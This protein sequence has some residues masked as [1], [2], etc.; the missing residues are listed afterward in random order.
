MP[1]QIQVTQTLTVKTVVAGKYIFYEDKT[2]QGSLTPKE[3]DH[4]NERDH[5][6]CASQGQAYPTDE[7]IRAVQE[8]RGLNRIGAVQY[9]RRQSAKAIRQP[10]ELNG[11][12]AELGDKAHK[13]SIEA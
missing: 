1:E 6:G 3:P 9:L 11:K 7:E 10:V 8:A 13:R 2:V 4:G 5:E 12:L